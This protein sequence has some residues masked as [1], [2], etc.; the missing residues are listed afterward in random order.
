MPFDAT[1]L[2]SDPA[3]SGSSVTS[4]K[5][6][7]PE[8][9]V[10]AKPAPPVAPWMTQGA[11]MDEEKRSKNEEDRKQSSSQTMKETGPESGINQATIVPEGQIQE[12]MR[13]LEDG[14]QMMG[15]RWY[16]GATY[17]DVWGWICQGKIDLNVL[18]QQCDMMGGQLRKF[19][20]W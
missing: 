13:D 4:K 9:P 16:P 8:K 12:S 5:Q 20:A 11:S 10:E 14:S 6:K 7:I 19:M 17:N 18:L 15:F 2:R 3:S 1:P